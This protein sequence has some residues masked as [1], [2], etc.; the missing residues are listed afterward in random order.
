MLNN[1]FLLKQT[2]QFLKPERSWLS[3]QLNKIESTVFLL[4][5]TDASKIALTSGKATMVSCDKNYKNR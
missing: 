1:H 2:F 3:R 5:F 4:T